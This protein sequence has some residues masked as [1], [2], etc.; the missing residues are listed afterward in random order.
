M[1][2]KECGAKIDPTGKRC[3]ACGAENKPTGGVGFWDIAEGPKPAPA[4][5]PVT[6]APPV[7]EPTAAPTPFQPYSATVTC[8]EGEKV[9]FRKKPWADSTALFRLDPGTVV[10]V[11]GPGTYKGKTYSKWVM[12]E[13][14]GTTGYIQREFLK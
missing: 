14:G 5:A 6:E 9:N 13:Y 2:C 8:K 10:T 4:P 12:V 1:I 11:V 3:P 7:V